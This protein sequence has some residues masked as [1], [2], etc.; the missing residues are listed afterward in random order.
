M[1]LKS[2]IKNILTY[3]YN[4]ISL[5]RIKSIGSN[6]HIGK[7]LQVNNGRGITLNN[8]IRLGR[9]CR[10]SCYHLN[11]RLGNIIIE[12]GCYIGDYFSALAG[13]DVVI[14]EGALIASY[15]S[16]LAENHSMNPES[17][18][19]YGLQELTGSPTSIGSYSWIGEKCIIMPGVSIG[20]W[21]IIGAGSVV[22]KSVPP[23]SV[24]V[25]NPA[26]VIKRYSF[27]SHSWE[28]V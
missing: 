17:G 3:I 8:S 1:K 7:G 19:R 5:F 4:P 16:V 25:G 21:S 14:S 23:Y 22:T 27:E 18:E 2:L 13:A 6:V 24:A 15:V 12:D 10:L 11:N 20:D 9:Y 26:K 28:K